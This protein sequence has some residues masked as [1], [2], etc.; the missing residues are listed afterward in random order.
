[1]EDGE[2]EEIAGLPLDCVRVLREWDDA[3]TMMVRLHYLY[4]AI[5]TMMAARPHR[6]ARAERFCVA[7]L[8]RIARRRRRQLEELLAVR[9]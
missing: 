2:V 9:N 7:M 4:Q 6:S 8:L 5:A 1:M 3:E